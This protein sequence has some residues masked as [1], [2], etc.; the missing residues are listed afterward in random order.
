MYCDE[1]HLFEDARRQGC[2]QYRGPCCNYGSTEHSLRWCPAPFENTFSLLNPEFGTH[3]PNGS[4]FGTRKIRMLRWRQNAPPLGR[5]G[6]NGHNSSGNGRPRYTQNRGHKPK[7]HDNSSG[8]T[9]A[10]APVGARNFPQR[11]NTP[12]YAPP[13]HPLTMR[14]APTLLLVHTISHGGQTL[15]SMPLQRPLSL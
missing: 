4:V 12:Q 14:H 11:S 1:H 5:Q 2:V 3:N 9:R 10:N 7:Y 15:R 13:A 6:N 8:M